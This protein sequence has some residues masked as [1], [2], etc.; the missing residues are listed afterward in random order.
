MSR[1]EADQGRYDRTI[2]DLTVV[3]TRFVLAN[4]RSSVYID[5]S[6]LSNELYFQRL[7]A[8]GQIRKLVMQQYAGGILHNSLTKPRCDF[9]Q[10]GVLHWGQFRRAT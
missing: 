2:P 1:S 4:Q 9:Y 10:T 7:E 8:R 5:A 6:N 3:G